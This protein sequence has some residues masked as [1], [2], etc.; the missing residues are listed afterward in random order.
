MKKP[1]M[2]AKIKATWNG[3]GWDCIIKTCNKD[4]P[5]RLRRKTQV[6]NVLLCDE[7][8]MPIALCEHRG[9]DSAIICEELGI[10]VE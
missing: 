6:D 5:F 3:N 4:S 1:T 9:F 10:E 8:V 7:W 2:T